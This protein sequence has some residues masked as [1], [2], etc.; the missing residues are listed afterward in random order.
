ML[1]VALAWPSEASAT[2]GPATAGEASSPEG[3]DA[4]PEPP[5]DVVPTAE[6]EVP[7][8]AAPT[9]ELTPEELAQR[10]LDI[11]LED[12]VRYWQK[13]DLLFDNK[14]YAEAAE[15]FESSYA[16]YPAA[17]A[18]YSAAL[19]YEN[20]GKP[21]EAVRTL[22]RYLAY[23]DCPPGLT[24]EQRPVDCT[25][26][27]PLAEQALAEQRRRVGELVL[28][29]GEGVELREVR[30]AGRTVPLDDFPLLLLPGTVDVEVF[31]LGPD[32]RRTR[33][34][35]ITGGEVTTLYVAPFESDAVV[36][37]PEEPRPVDGDLIK[38]R[39]R[40][41]RITFW[42]G[43]GLT[44]A[45]GVATA[46]T[47]G[48][49]LYHQRRFETELCDPLCVE[50]DENDEPILDAAGNPIPLGGPNE[51]LYPH[52]HE[53]ELQRHRPIANALVGVTIGLAVA[54]VLVGTFAFRKRAPDRASNGKPSVR[55]RV[56]THVGLGGSGLVV[57]W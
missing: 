30:V 19:S 44:A 10:R 21:V 32:E 55:A 45:A 27:R 47:G 23:A 35:Y 3:P 29:L 37:P 26:Q 40:Q 38:R 4:K 25:A 33:P 24:Q 34:A 9:V 57:R 12:A 39:R 13:G 28:S 50:R 42:V 11:G 49:A 43:T 52:D 36:V 41:Q 46:V 48:I 14:R 56:R 31:G 18:L 8:P 20:A 6:G 22:Q 17:E 53:A 16:A 54:T 2:R 7:V 5:G 51:D 15:A 1:V